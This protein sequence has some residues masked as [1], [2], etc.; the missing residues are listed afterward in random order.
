MTC[1]AE[2]TDVFMILRQRL[3]IFK[4]DRG[5]QIQQLCQIPLHLN[6]KIN[7]NEVLNEI[8]RDHGEISLER[9]CRRLG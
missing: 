8:K 5:N 4:C 3:M 1:Y 2:M 7:S 6:E 9:M